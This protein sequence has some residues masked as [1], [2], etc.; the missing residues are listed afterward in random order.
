MLNKVKVISKWFF[1]IYLGIFVLSF[2]IALFLVII[3]PDLVKNSL[4][5][6]YIALIGLVLSLPGMVSQLAQ[7]VNPRKKTYKLSSNSFYV[8]FVNLK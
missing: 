8:D 7:E 5:V 1:R 2:M 3:S 4:T 6:N